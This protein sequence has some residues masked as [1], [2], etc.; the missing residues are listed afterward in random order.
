MLKLYRKCTSCGNSI[1]I[2]D[3]P[4]HRIVEVKCDKCGKEF[5][6]YDIWRQE[7]ILSSKDSFM[8]TCYKQTI[9]EINKGK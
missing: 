4:Y 8:E 3:L 6:I 5:V 9:K 1:E 2:R 7:F